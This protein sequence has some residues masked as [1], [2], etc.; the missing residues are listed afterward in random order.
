MAKQKEEGLWIKFSKTVT[1]C[2]ETELPRLGDEVILD[3]PNR[4]TFTNDEV[5]AYPVDS[6]RLNENATNFT[7]ITIL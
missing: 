7:L 4:P 1:D 5:T 2:L 3:M 6:K